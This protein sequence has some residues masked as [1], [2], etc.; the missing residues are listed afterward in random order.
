MLLPTAHVQNRVPVCGQ[1]RSPVDQWVEQARRKVGVA[2]TAGG[3]PSDH[4]SAPLLSF[5]H[6]TQSQCH[7]I[8]YHCHVIQGVVWTALG[9]SRVPL[10][11]ERWPLA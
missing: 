5:D 6:V 7:V 8:E 11:W 1:F 4:R 2:R 9:Q 10:R 3:D